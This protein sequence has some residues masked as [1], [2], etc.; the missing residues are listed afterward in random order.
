MFPIFFT[1]SFCL[2]V[3]CGFHAVTYLSLDLCLLASFVEV[4]FYLCLRPLE[5]RSPH[6]VVGHVVAQKVVKDLWEHVVELAED[7]HVWDVG[8]SKRKP[9]GKLKSLT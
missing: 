5:S 2:R 6:H 9:H 8:V 4:L 1:L 7:E 3:C